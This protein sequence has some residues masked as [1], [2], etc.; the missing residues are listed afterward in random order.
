MA[1]TAAGQFRIF[2]AH[3]GI[4]GPPGVDVV[5]FAHLRPAFL[6]SGLTRSRDPR[7]SS[8]RLALLSLTFPRSPK[9]SATLTWTLGRL[10]LTKNIGDLADP[11]AGELALL[12]S[13]RAIRENSQGARIRRLSRP[14]PY[15]WN[16]DSGSATMPPESVNR[17]L[18]RIAVY[19]RDL[20]L[21][22]SSMSILGPGLLVISR[23]PAA[24]PNDLAIF[25]FVC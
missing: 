25:S 2:S 23:L 5:I 16:A 12:T 20:M 1:V 8:R 4:P 21:P 24:E 13:R 6:G 9:P 22:S 10:S 15:R 11:L 18:R 17:G 14:F 7:R 19:P 3:T